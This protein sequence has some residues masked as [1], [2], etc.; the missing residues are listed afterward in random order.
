MFL[1]KTFVVV[2]ILLFL[3]FTNSTVFATTKAQYH[4][5]W[6]AIS[7]AKEYD[8]CNTYYKQAIKD[9]PNEAWFY[10][11]VGHCKKMQK[12]YKEA[13]FYYDKALKLA[14]K[15]QQIIDNVYYGYTAYATYVMYTLREYKAGLA[16][17]KKAI[18]ID[19]KNAW[20]YNLTGNA[21]RNLMQY[22][23][24]YPYYAKSYELNPK[25]MENQGFRNNFRAGVKDG[26]TQAT[27]TLKIEW[28]KLTLKIFGDD[29]ELTMLALT[30]LV[31]TDEKKGRAENGRKETQK[32]NYINTK[33]IIENFLRKN[34]DA[35]LNVFA[36]AL[37]KLRN[38]QEEDA[39]KDFD[40]VS[41][42]MN[43]YKVDQ[44]IAEIYKQK[45]QSLNYYEMMKSKYLDKQL[46]FNKRSVD[47]YFT[48][49]PFRLKEALLPPL[50]G[51]FC[52]SQT[53]GGRSYHNGLYG[54]YNYDLYLCSG[55]SMGTPIYAVS[56]GVVIEVVDGN[57]DH[58]V[59]AKVN[60]E[61]KPNFI[62]I[63][64][65]NYIS[66][67]VHNKQNS[68]RVKVGQEVIAGQQIAQIGNSGVSTGPHLH[69][70]IMNKDHIALPTYF[71]QLK[72][73]PMKNIGPLQL[74]KR[75]WP[76]YQFEGS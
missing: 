36:N 34:K 8:K 54:H 4:K 11:F 18:A 35:N 63:Q 27:S 40:S 37:M 17:H 20:G 55:D 5:E 67:Y 1:K 3:S 28:A 59:G 42:K 31:L 72:G 29:R 19:E 74:L 51:K 12:Q 62:K 61:A 30:A 15:D 6:T 7:A 56:V 16:W 2:G 76:Y 71:K 50:R 41:N 52:S 14:P 13:L 68:A 75:L 25:L 73:R 22:D 46:I 48:K 66:F 43:D 47:R 58:P 33:E 23:A 49:N 65:S 44:S 21:Y 45:M 57:T 53:E 69:F 64:H 9:Y 32:D 26:M 39:F 38:G 60:L 24:S 70:Q 10:I